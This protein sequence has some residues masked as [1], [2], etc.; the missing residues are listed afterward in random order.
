MLWRQYS[1]VTFMTNLMQSSKW[2]SLVLSNMEYPITNVTHEHLMAYQLKW[3]ATIFFCS[4]QDL[5]KPYF[6]IN[7]EGTLL[8]IF[9]RKWQHAY[10]GVLEDV[11]KCMTSYYRLDI[12]MSLLAEFWHCRKNR[13]IV[14]R[15][16]LQC[17]PVSLRYDILKTR[18]NAPLTLTSFNVELLRWRHIFFA[19]PRNRVRS[20]L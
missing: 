1:M 16:V 17:Y 18:E 7:F 11:K 5:W 3:L 8:E 6:I 19:A 20:W 15:I 12:Q 10:A 2:P 13:I 14:K 9:I 4:S